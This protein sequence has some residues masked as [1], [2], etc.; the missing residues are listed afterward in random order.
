MD[1]G[2]DGVQLAQGL[3]DARLGKALLARL[4]RKR[5]AL[6]LRDGA[7][8]S[9]G[10]GLRSGTILDTLDSLRSVAEAHAGRALQ[11]KKK[12][13]RGEGEAMTGRHTTA[14]ACERAPAA[15]QGAWMPQQPAPPGGVACRA[16]SSANARG[17]GPRH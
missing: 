3:D 15:G 6:Y 2:A 13:A 4:V 8:L 14:T 17:T 16:P 11:V 7:G 5:G 12:G 1:G 10:T 9:L